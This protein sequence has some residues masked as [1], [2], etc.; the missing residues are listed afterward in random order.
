MRSAPAHTYGVA[1]SRRQAEASID[2]P[3][4]TRDATTAAAAYEQLRHRLGPRL[5]DEERHN[6]HDHPHWDAYRLAIEEPSLHRLLLDALRGEPD[7]VMALEPVFAFIEGDDPSLAQMAL[8]VL[9]PGSREQLMAEQRASDV[10]LVRAAAAG[11]IGSAEPA[12]T[13]SK[14]AQRRACGTATDLRVLDLLA[15][16]GF[17]RHVRAQAAERARRFRR[18]RGTQH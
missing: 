17:S 1:D 10:A 14:W 8:G 4:W 6:G 5:V 16:N 12:D 11:D 18:E 13:W 9:A 7:Q 3:E 15:S 2:A